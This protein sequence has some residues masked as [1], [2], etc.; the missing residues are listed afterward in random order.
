[1]LMY[2]WLERIT[3]AARL[4]YRGAVAWNALPSGVKDVGSLSAFKINLKR[5]IRTF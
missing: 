5:N 4:Y 1:M 2:H 3:Y